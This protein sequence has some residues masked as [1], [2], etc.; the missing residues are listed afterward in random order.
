LTYVVTPGTN[1]QTPSGG[2]TICTF[3]VS[4]NL[5]VS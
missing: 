1:T 4:G 5:K 2:D 3:T